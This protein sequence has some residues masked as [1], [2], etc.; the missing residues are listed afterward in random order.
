MVRSQLVR[1][2]KATGF[3][4]SDGGVYVNSRGPRFET[5]AE[6]PVAL[7]LHPQL[8]SHRVCPCPLLHRFGTLLPWVTWWA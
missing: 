2:L 1:V 7:E 5:K 3:D 6:V 4:P 8:M